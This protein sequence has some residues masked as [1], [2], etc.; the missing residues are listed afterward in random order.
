M[1]VRFQTTASGEEIAVMSR[2]D[3]DTMKDALD[4]ASAMTDYRSGKTP[5]LTPAEMRD[6]MAA[7]SALAFWRRYRGKTQAEMAAEI[8]IAQNY[9]SDIENGKREGGIG[10]WLKFSE[11]LALPVEAIFE[12]DD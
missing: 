8:G 1:T 6:M 11:S 2:A 12:A 4:H 9:L 7:P 10:L 5:G 3:Y